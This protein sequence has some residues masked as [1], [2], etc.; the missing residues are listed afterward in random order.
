MQKTREI[1]QLRLEAIPAVGPIG[2]FMRFLLG[3]PLLALPPYLI[4]QDPSFVSLTRFQ[5]TL[6]LLPHGSMSDLP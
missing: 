2:L 6:E 1:N 3:P 5:A 4:E